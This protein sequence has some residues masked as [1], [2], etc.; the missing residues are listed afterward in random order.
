MT[1]GPPRPRVARKAQWARVRNECHGQAACGRPVAGEGATQKGRRPSEPPY[2]RAAYVG[3]QLP[4][5]RAGMHFEVPARPGPSAL[6]RDKCP[7][8]TP[9]ARSA[10]LSRAEQ[11]SELLGFGLGW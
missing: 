5:A 7:P 6:E 8:P 1:D 11:N 2:F 10:S 4:V 9:S 3:S